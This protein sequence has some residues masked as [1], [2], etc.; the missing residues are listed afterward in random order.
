MPPP[1]PRPAKVLFHPAGGAEVPLTA[2]A[3]PQRG[4]FPQL[5]QRRVEYFF[6]NGHHG[7][8]Q[9]VLEH[10]W[11]HGLPVQGT[12]AGGMEPVVEAAA[13]IDSALFPNEQVKIV[14]VRETGLLA[15]HCRTFPA[16]GPPYRRCPVSG[17]P[18]VSAPGRSAGGRLCAFLGP[19][20]K[21]PPFPG[22]DRPVQRSDSFPGR[23]ARLPKRPAAASPASGSQ[24]RRLPAF[25]KLS[26]LPLM[27][28][29]A[30]EAKP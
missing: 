28:V 11:R 21:A 3:S 18:A 4:V 13:L 5:L 6:Q 8:V 24:R 17:T 15:C 16:P 10:L 1:P 29:N 27:R 26:S 7:A 23:R 30:V 12:E 14:F 2:A 20:R 9:K 25:A 19:A 22:K